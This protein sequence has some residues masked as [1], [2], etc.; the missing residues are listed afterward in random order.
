MSRT[1]WKTKKREEQQ[2][3]KKMIVL[4]AI[5]STLLLAACGR[6]ET[7]TTPTITRIPAPNITQAPVATPQPTVTPIETPPTPIVTPPSADVN[8]II[9]PIEVFAE[10]LVALWG[11]VESTGLFFMLVGAIDGEQF[12]MNR[13]QDESV[14]FYVFHPDSEALTI[15]RETGMLTVAGLDITFP[16]HLNNNLAMLVHN[17]SDYSDILELFMSLQ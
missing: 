14:E 11:N 5:T 16:A 15:A 9:N 12:I 8:I 17:I 4:L 7:T 1:L 3:M 2:K 10:G 6:G 13:Y